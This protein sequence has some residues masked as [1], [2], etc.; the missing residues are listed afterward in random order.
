MKNN[1][2]NVEKCFKKKITDNL[3]SLTWFISTIFL[4]IYAVLYV[5]YIASNNNI[6]VIVSEAFFYT[7]KY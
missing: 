6:F 4:E 7:C 5:Q 1:K 3:F 2:I